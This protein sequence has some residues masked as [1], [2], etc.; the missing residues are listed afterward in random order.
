V[1]WEI[2]GSVSGLV[3][4]LVAVL[5]LWR[6]TRRESGEDRRSEIAAA[7]SSAVSPVKDALTR[8]SE[9]ISQLTD[10]D[11]KMATQLSDMASRVAV[12]DTKM[13]VFWRSVAL[14]AAKILHS[15]NPARRHVDELLEELMA[16]TISDARKSELRGILERVRDYHAG[17]RTDFPIYPG[18]RV[19]AAI[20]LR[21]M[22]YVG[23]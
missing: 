13:E 2:A 14:D 23:R 7:V 22:E 16:G 3:G 5:A 18:E 21:T 17:D 12:L 20:L 9:R 6:T 19:A 4:S 10:A 1:I 11:T 8:N 15:P